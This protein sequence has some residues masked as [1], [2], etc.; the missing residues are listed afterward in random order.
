[1]KLKRC[2]NPRFFRNSVA[3]Q[4]MILRLALGAMQATGIPM[5]GS[6]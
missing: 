3:V 4:S 1:M 2:E 5:R 6:R